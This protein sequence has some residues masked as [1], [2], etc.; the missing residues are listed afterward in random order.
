MRKKEILKSNQKA[1]NLVNFFLE[2]LI[3]RHTPRACSYYLKGPVKENIVEHLYFTTIIGWVISKLE[4]VDENK[5]IKMCLIHDLVE[6]RG[7]PRNIIMKFYNPIRNERE[8]IKEIAKDHNLEIIQLEDLF[9]EYFDQKTPEA[10][11]AKDADVLARMLLEKECFDLGNE[12]AKKWLNFS[13][14]RLKTKSGKEL[15]KNLIET[16][17]DEW[18]LKIIEKYFQI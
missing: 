15:G 16:D 17:S 13:F 8:I 7:G 1:K 4:E 6:S 3:L 5:I 2:C 10:I 11:A 18:W 12:K 14:K 9:N